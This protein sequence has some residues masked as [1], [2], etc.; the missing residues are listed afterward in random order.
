MKR[1]LQGTYVTIS[2]VG[3][4]VRAFVPAPLPPRPSID[5]TPNLRN[6]FD[7][8]LLTLGRLDSVSTL[9]PDTS[10]LL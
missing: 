3:E 6:K 8:A 7:Q 4:T 9:L 5:W 2:T 10:L 1:D